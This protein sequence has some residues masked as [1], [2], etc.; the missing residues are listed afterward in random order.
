MAI[1]T[2]PFIALR[3]RDRASDVAGLRHRRSAAAVDH[4]RP[5]ACSPD[6][7]HGGDRPS[8]L[9]DYLGFIPLF[10]NEIGIYTKSI[11]IARSVLAISDPADDLRTVPRGAPSR[12]C[13]TT[14]AS[15]ALV[16]CWESEI[17][18]V[19]LPRSLRASSPPPCWACGVGETIAVLSVA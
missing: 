12:C 6:E 9:N 14:E 10:N 1:G 13:A 2:A 3:L 5:G 18:M 7:P 11:F 15:L 19:V 17:R 8:G 4:L 16:T